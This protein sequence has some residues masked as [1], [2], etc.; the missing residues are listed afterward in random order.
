MSGEKH[1]LSLANSAFHAELVVMA[2]N[3]ANIRGKMKHNMSSYNIEIPLLTEADGLLTK[4]DLASRLKLS[5]RMVTVWMDQGRLLHFKV[6]KSVRFD[7]GAVMR[8]L[9]QYQVG[10]AG[11]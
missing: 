11:R 6:G 1:L 9:N 4:R 8:S 5:H 2:R 10:G 7:Y 3:A